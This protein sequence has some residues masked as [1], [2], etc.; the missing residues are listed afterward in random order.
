MRKMFGDVGRSLLLFVEAPLKGKKFSFHEPENFL[1]SRDSTGSNA[2][3][4]LNSDDTQVS[5]NH[6]LLDI[7]PPDCFIRDT[8]NDC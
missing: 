7:N 4:R 1:L 3:F 8:R 6:F 5:R 2:H